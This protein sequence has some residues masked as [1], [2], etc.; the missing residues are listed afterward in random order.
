MNEYLWVNYIFSFRVLAARPGEMVI[1]KFE[2]VEDTKGNNG[3]TGD[4]HVHI[5][6]MSCDTQVNWLCLTCVSYGSQWQ[7]LQLIFVSFIN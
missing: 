7:D 4:S 5:T 2:L 3:A 1:D 6:C